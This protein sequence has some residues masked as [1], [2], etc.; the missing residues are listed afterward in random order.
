[1]AQE[2]QAHLTC[3]HVIEKPN[4]DG[5]IRPDELEASAIR[6]MQKLVTAATELWCKPRYVTR[7]GKPAYAIL[8]VANAYK[9]DLIVLGLRKAEGI[10]GG[11]SHLPISAAHK[12][13]A[14]AVCPVLTIRA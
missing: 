14:N 4:V 12:I 5:A 2:H 13:I 7:E 11:A 6:Q 10:P 1:M 3:F 8:E 9:S